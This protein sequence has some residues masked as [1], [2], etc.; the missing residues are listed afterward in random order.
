M[1]PRKP[2]KRTPGGRAKTKPIPQPRR[3]QPG[4]KMPDGTIYAGVSPHTGAAMYV[5]PSDT[6]LPLPFDHARQYA[7]D[8]EAHS[9]RDWRLPTKDELNVIFGNREAIGGFNLTGLGPAGSA[10][11]SSSQKSKFD[12]CSQ[13]FRDGA[14]FWEY[15]GFHSNVR[16]V[17]A[18]LS[19]ELLLAKSS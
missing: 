17:R 14:Q 2:K 15:T 7:A 16:C 19:F 10:Y 1:P 3:F 13:R 8:L 4:H 6:P 5:T 12:A 11:W 9:H 18:A